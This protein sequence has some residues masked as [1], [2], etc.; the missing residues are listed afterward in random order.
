MARKYSYIVDILHI[1]YDLDED[2]GVWL[3]T[4]MDIDDYHLEFFVN[5]LIQRIY[6]KNE[7]D[8]NLFAL[9]IINKHKSD[10]FHLYEANVI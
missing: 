6:F 8:R 2:I 7:E 3:D 9:N 5:G 10:E 4:N 1:Y